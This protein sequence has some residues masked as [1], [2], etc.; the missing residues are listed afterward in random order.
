MQENVDNIVGKFT[1][2]KE[3]TIITTRQ[4]DDKIEKLTDLLLNLINKLD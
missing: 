1:E 4:L 2:H 3:N